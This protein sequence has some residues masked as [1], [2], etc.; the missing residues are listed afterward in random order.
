MRTPSRVPRILLTLFV[1]A[2]GHVLAGLYT[3]LAMD[4]HLGA[5]FTPETNEPLLEHACISFAVGGLAGGGVGALWSL[6]MSRLPLTAGADRIMLRGIGLGAIA[7]LVAMLLVHLGLEIIYHIH[8]DV[9]L[10]FV[11]FPLFF[12]IPMGLATGL[13]SSLLAWGVAAWE[14]RWSPAHY[15]AQGENACT[16][17]FAPLPGAVWG[18]VI[19]FGSLGAAALYEFF[20]LVVALAFNEEQTAFECLTSIALGTAGGGA[21]AALW[22]SVMAQLRPDTH[23]VGNALTGLILGAAEGVV[24]SVFVIPGWTV[25]T[26]GV[27]IL[28]FLLPVI[29]G[30][31]ALGGLLWGS[32]LE[33]LLW[34]SR[35]LGQYKTNRRWLESS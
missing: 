23:Y 14:R 8:Y 17:N 9:S 12:G 27:N 29:L 16:P 28:P 11:L 4:Q 21:A 2:V 26:G 15:A 22:L 24:T 13:V 1:I 19:L 32:V 34:T 10:V 7:A 6:L 5:S 3:F 35:L 20:A 25:I 30:G 33:V 18:L 31:G